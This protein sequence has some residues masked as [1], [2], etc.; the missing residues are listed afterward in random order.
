MRILN[1]KDNFEFKRE[2]KISRLPLIFLSCLL[3]VGCSSD[4]SS[5]LDDGVSMEQVQ[6]Y[7]QQDRRD[8]LLNQFRI[9]ADYGES[10][11]QYFLGFLYW[12][13][14]QQRSFDWFKRS[15]ENGCLEGALIVAQAYYESEHVKKSEAFH[16]YLK[17]AQAGDSNA[18]RQVASMYKNGEGVEVDAEQARFWS[19]KGWQ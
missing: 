10:A 9:R 6:R 7:L 12:S 17:A 8:E 11:A 13:E 4:L 19:S 16:W 3:L 15:A 1:I 5:C 2:M 14:D 18:I